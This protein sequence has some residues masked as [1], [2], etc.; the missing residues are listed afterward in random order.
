[1]KSIKI[2]AFTMIVSLLVIS[3]DK[4]ITQIT[5]T[6]D[7]NKY[8]EL[9]EN[10]ALHKAINDRRFW[11]SKLEE[12]PDQF[13]YLAQLA[14]SH[15]QLFV[16]TGNIEDLI[17]A[18]SYLVK[19]NEVTAY[20]NAG[21]IR[22]LAKN[23]ISQHRFKDAL[24]ILKKA[25]ILAEN[26][27]DTE[28]MLFDVNLELGRFEEAKDY[29]SKIENQSD[30]DYLIRLSKWLDH[31]GQLNEAIIAMDRAL[32]IA[33]ASKNK[34]L[35]EWAYTNIA[36]FYGHNGQ[37]K[38]SYNHYLEALAINPY[39]AYA[40]KGIAWIVYSFERN[41][42]EANRIISAIK[43]QHSSPDYDLFEAEIAEF[44]GNES[45]MQAQN[46]KFINAI[47]QPVYGSMYNVYKVLLLSNDKSQIELAKKIALEEVENRATPLA[48][49]LLA[50][51]Y[52]KA[53][54]H[55][56]ALD[57]IETFVYGK[58][59]EPETLLRMA[60]IYKANLVEN[61]LNQIKR[62]LDKANYELGPVN[63]QKIKR[64]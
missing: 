63:A 11:E 17:K 49:D 26:L 23:Y 43:Q 59:E 53:N 31:A 60:E 34:S 24:L 21:Y 2:L 52:H 45:Q 25:E 15:S 22:S 37:I 3:C 1:M 18:E 61:K 35:M 64:L 12:H 30:F 46:T 14:A 28:K 10:K 27:N 42:Q 4:N 56:L 29:L 41:P 33:E 55:E 13:P 20:K 39:N 57:I 47:S 36:D 19:A 44:V 38:K 9:N 51:T 5:N 32:I 6:D 58:T 48:Y 62:V 8:V 16:I 50:W 54:D 7:Y 40:K